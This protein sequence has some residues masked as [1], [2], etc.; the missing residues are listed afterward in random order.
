MSLINY[1][2]IKLDNS[3]ALRA[4]LPLHS[5]DSRPSLPFPD[6]AHL[7]PSNQTLASSSSNDAFKT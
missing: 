4:I 6:K 2:K 5:M 7:H 3:S 1:P